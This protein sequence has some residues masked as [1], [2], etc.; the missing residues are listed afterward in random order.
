MCM[1]EHLRISYLEQKTN[2]CVRSKINFLVGPQKPL[3]ATVKMKKKKERKKENMI[4]AC[5][6]PL[7]LP[8][9]ILQGTVEG[10]GCRG[11]QRK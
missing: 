7:Q 6:T 10:G 3:L 8:K 5:H 11:W 2:E 1:R 4:W 9:T